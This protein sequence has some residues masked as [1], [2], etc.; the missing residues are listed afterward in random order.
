MRNDHTLCDP[1]RSLFKKILLCCPT[2]C[3]CLRQGM[4][5]G[6]LFQSPPA[7]L[8]HC[9]KFNPKWHWSKSCKNLLDFFLFAGY[10]GIGLTKQYY[11]VIWSIPSRTFAVFT[12]KA[13]VRFISYK[14]GFRD[15]A[16]CFFHCV[17]FCLYLRCT[18]SFQN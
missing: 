18:L 16:F 14:E 15:C 8:K 12:V 5:V 6:A 10:V 3:L 13:R 2:S 1:L 11:V 4:C 9:K 17:C 7:L